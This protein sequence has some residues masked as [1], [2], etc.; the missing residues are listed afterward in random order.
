MSRRTILTIII[1]PALLVSGLIV[2]LINNPRE[3]PAALVLAQQQVHFGALPEWK[4]PVTQSVTARNIG[5]DTLHIQRIQTGC[6]YAEVKGPDVIQPDGEGTFQIVLN[7]ELLPTNETAATAAIFTDS[8]KTPIVSLTI[9]AAAK[10]FATLNPDV[11]EFGDILPGTTH[12]KEVSLSVNA[13]LNTSKIRL[14]TSTHKEVTWK[15]TSTQQTDTFLI[16]IQ[17]GLVKDRGHFSSLLTVA[18]PNERTLTLPITAKVVS[19]VTV[20]PQTLFYGMGVPDTAQ[21]LEFTLS[22]KIPFEVLKVEVPT[23]LAVRDL[24]NPNEHYQKRL[25][26]VWTVPNS[27]TPLRGEIQI[28]TTVDTFPI[29]IPVYGFVQKD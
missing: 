21:S 25:K 14:L 12:R 16:E 10:R 27:S 4:G 1:I 26:I 20:Q 5:R 13:P 22:A 23:D 7:P 6:G 29:Y 8:P 24:S 28:L 11:C 3:F 17:L 18:F 19:P 2:T 9:T 15:L